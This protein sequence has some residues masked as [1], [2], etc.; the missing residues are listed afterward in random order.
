MKTHVIIGIAVVSVGA[1]GAALFGPAAAQ[2]SKEPDLSKGSHGVPMDPQQQRE[3][4][5]YMM[6]S[7]A[8]GPE[9][10]RLKAMEGKWRQ[11]V[12]MAMA[13]DA[14][15]MQA[16]STGE[17]RLILGGRFLQGT[18][19]GEFMGQPFESLNIMGFD[20]RHDHYTVVGFDTMGTYYVAA[21]GKWDD[22]TQS[23]RMR[24]ETH[25]PKIK[26]TERYTMVYK[27]VSAD[28]YIWEIWFDKHDGGEFRIVHVRNVR[29]N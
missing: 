10:E 8:P 19:L 22:K 16:E 1:L 5:E 3:L 2:D 13:P 9:H 25:D 12:T 17:N 29:M 23:I 24:G 11:F 7:M 14:P 20:R 21:E 26:A 15:E 18:A 6:N 4:Q 27:P 28:E